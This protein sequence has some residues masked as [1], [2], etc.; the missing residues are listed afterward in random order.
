MYTLIFAPSGGGEFSGLGDSLYRLIQSPIV[1]EIV[2]VTTFY[3]AEEYHQDDY[4]K[5]SIHYKLYQ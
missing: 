4:K 5:D 3:Q 1:T 2:P